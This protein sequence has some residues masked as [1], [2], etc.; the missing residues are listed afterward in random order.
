MRFDNSER[1]VSERDIESVETTLGI[2]LPAELRASYLLSNGGCPNPYVFENDEVDTVV[3]AFLPLKAA[4]QE[5]AVDVYRHLV[6]A[7]S[8]V[9]AELF[10]FAADG[11]GDYFFVDC[12]PDTGDVY[13]FASDTASG[14][15]LIALGLSVEEFWSGLKEE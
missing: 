14:G 9:A 15:E 11:G 3:A 13:F 5:T 1:P 10:P 8:V 12:S 6:L 4:A 2:S 7:E